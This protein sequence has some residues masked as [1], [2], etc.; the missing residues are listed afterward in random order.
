MSDSGGYEG[1]SQTLT[2]ETTEGGTLT[3]RY[4][5]YTITDRSVIRYEGK[6]LLD[7]GFTGGSATGTI[8]IP[9][10]DSDQIEILVI[11]NDEGIELGCLAPTRVRHVADLLEHAASPPDL[12]IS[13][14]FWKRKS[15]Q[16]N[17]PTSGRI[18]DQ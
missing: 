18:R 7:T 4:E 16:R 1:S 5:H 10:G 2:L 6:D 12:Q 14:D 9:A 3:Y 17:R 8:E 13:P 15:D 11:T